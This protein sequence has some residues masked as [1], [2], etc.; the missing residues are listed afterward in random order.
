VALADAGIPMKSMI[1][2]CADG[3]VADT[4]ILDPMKEEDNFGQ[5]D[6]PIAMTPGG[7]ITLLQMDGNLTPDEFQ[8]AVEM[9]MK[10]ARYI[11]EL[12][13]DALVKKYS[14]MAEQPA[15]EEV[16]ACD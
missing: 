11:Y 13:R 2:S 5:A 4:I 15:R 12:Q 3:K 10:G 1:S 7:D 14:Q 16:H 6:L 8:G 9:A